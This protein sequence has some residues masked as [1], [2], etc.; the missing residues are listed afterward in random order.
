MAA[1]YRSSTTANTGTTPA[2]TLTINTPAGTVVGDCLYAAIGTDSTVGVTVI[3]TGWSLLKSLAEGSAHTLRVYF[4]L[5][6]GAESASYTWTFGT[7]TQASG[8]MVGYYGAS[9]FAPTVY[10]LTSSGTAST[11]LTGVSINNVWSGVSL[12]F[13]ATRNTTAQ[14]TI[15][16]ASGWTS[17]A[18]TSS[19]SADFIETAVFELPRTLPAS[20]I[21]APSFTG[22]QSVTY[23]GIAI[24]IDDA[25]ASVPLAIDEIFNSGFNVATS[26]STLQ[27][28]TNYPNEL[29][30]AIV[31]LEL[32]TV[33]VSSITGTGLTF[34]KLGSIST[35]GGDCE[36]WY[37]L[38][39]T[40][41]S[42]VVVTAA[43]SGSPASGNFMALGVTGIDLTSITG[44]NAI[45]AIANANA[46]ASSTPT[47]SLTT[48]RNNSWVFAVCN[49]SNT[50]K[51]TAPGTGQSNLHDHTNSTTSS[52]LV[53]MQTAP[54]QTSGTSVTMSA[55]SS[56]VTDWN[57]YAFEVLP[58][59]GH[60]LSL[61]GA[62]T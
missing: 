43:Y 34:T 6:T 57:I 61:G 50:S 24:S 41:I 36:V 11:T 20:G 5:A 44:S 58:S 28:Y 52:S 29:L 25:H 39:P 23:I 47:V 1:T 46:A 19:T 38:A 8:L 7:T 45:G 33:S 62:G 56:T 49:S 9:G 40:L 4:R 53:M 12:Y 16:A 42:N 22:S 48:T 27:V 51:L 60:G 35:Q 18:D 54:T 31:A 55:S 26:N 17:R 3:P 15:T 37:A 32:G 14:D 30:L 13:W 21:T 2:N 10:S 59:F